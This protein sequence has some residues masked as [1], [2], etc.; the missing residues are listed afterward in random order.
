MHLYRESLTSD[1]SPARGR[2]GSMPYDF[3]SPQ[4]RPR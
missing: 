3:R 1:M 2:P 4:R